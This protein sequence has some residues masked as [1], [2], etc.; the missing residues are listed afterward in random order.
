[1]YYS[2]ENRSPFLDYKL[3]EFV[4]S[5]PT[6]HLINNG[7][8]KYLLRSAFQ[9]ILNDNVRNDKRKIG[10]NSSVDANF[11]LQNSEVKNYFFDKKSNIFEFVK[12]EKIT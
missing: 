1:M 8:S 2:I 5:V 9:G 11:D 6:K 10:F 4:Y 12:I 3:V 7:F